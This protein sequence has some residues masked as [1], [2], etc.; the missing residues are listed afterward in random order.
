M[1]LLSRCLGSPLSRRNF[2]HVGCARR[3]RPDARPVHPPPGRRTAPRSRPRPRR[4]STSSCRAAWPTRRAGTR[5]RSPR[6]STAAR[7][8][9]M[10]T[11]L[12]GVRLQRVPEEDGRRSRTRSP[13]AAAMTHGEAAHERGTH[14]MFTGYRPSPALTFP[15]MG[16]VVSHELGRAQQPA[17][18]RLRAEPCRPTTPAAATC[19]RAFAPFSL[20]S[21]PANGGFKVQDLTL[22]GGVDARA[23][24]HPARRCSTRST[25]TSP[26]RRSPT[27]STRWTPS[28]SGPTA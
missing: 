20:G 6:S 16:S 1:N 14:N 17:A 12:D 19:R 9:P 27:T 4:A 26:A 25:T 8:A 23:V 13:S 22:P 18:V 3:P 5:S 28:T 24:R 7:W 21:D 15:S 10:K 2:L 11:K